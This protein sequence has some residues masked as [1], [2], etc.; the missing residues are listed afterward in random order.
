MQ[1]YKKKL[2]WQK[3]WYADGRVCVPISKLLSPYFFTGMAA[4]VARR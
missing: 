3:K 2:N 1:K 4:R